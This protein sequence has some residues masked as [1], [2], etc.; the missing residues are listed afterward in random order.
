MMK[1][2]KIKI[3]NHSRE[4]RKKL[5]ASDTRAM[6]DIAGE[7]VARV[8]TSFDGVDDA[9]IIVQEGR[10][11]SRAVVE[12]V[13]EVKDGGYKY[14]PGL[15][16]SSLNRGKIEQKSDAGSKN[17]RQSGRSSK[18]KNQRKKTRGR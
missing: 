8:I 17:Q 5:N 11:R 7:E 1:N 16:Q 9:N 10:K 2:P 12:A 14:I 3:K 6:L 18:R 4:Y 15:K 13:P